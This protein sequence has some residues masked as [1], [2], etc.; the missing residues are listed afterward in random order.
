[1]FD[2]LLVLSRL[3]GYDRRPPMI[4]DYR[5]YHQIER[6]L[7][8]EVGPRFRKSGKLSTLDFYLILVWKANRAK[9][10]VRHRLEKKLGKFDLAVKTIAR[11]IYKADHP[12]Q[13]LKIL[14]KDWGLLLP[15]ATAILCI[16]YP[17]EFTI[18]D[19]RVCES[20]GDFERLANRVFS[21]KLWEGY[22]ELL[23]A[24]RKQA[25]AKYTLR[26][27][28]RHLWGLSLYREIKRDLRSF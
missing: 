27:A 2:L 20:L 24:V 6:Y 7:L 10:K 17:N 14:M 13:K 1:M 18:Y 23:Q 12:K 9:S 5:N 11:S 16:L 15:M 25:P 8:E 21:D 26:D 19:R 4:R 22:Q 3:R 28:D